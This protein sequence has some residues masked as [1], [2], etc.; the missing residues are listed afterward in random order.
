MVDIRTLLQPSQRWG[1]A[2][3]RVI[4]LQAVQAVL[5]AF[6]TTR[7]LIFLIIFLSSVALPMREGPFLYANPGN[8]LID[9][10]VRDDSWWY[11]NIVE[12][13]YSVGDVATHV[14]GNAVFF[15]LYPLL[16]SVVAGVTGSIYLAGILVS[17]AA[18]ILAL[19]YLYRLVRQQF[20][21]ETA[22]R[23]IFYMAAAPAA[24][25]F[26]AIYTESLY[27]ALVCATFFYAQKGDWLP[28]MLAGALVSATRNTGIILT[29]VIV[30]EGLHQQGVRIIPRPLWAGTPAATI[31]AWRG[32]FQQQIQL[33]PSC[34][35]SLTAAAWVPAGLLAFMA[36][37]T[38]QFNDPL[39]FIH[40]Q[41]T[42][43]RP[44]GGG[45]ATRLISHT[46]DLLNIG[47][48]FWAGQVHART[49]LELIYSLAVAPL[50]VAVVW[51]LRPAYGLYA[52]ASF[53]I[54]LSTGTVGS[55]LRYTLVLVPCYILLAHWGRR[56]WVDRL[57]V[58]VFLPLMA[59]LAIIFS[60]WY[61]AG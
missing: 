36:Y 24:V 13:G 18:F 17:N 51:K 12:H 28:A 46:I 56:G 38:M 37:L 59:Y 47:P 21:H 31:A 34:F 43:G 7:L 1:Q 60:H 2:L 20:D 26:S 52:A 10:L 40:T 53:L 41:A 5:V 50:I 23:A 22:A 32:H 61:F 49:L 19:S 4:D 30:F 3:L 57:V 45:S 29:G 27:V 55:M 48:H 11:V 25:F 33:L 39:A 6:L 9:G 8:L 14:Q 54:P 15:P 42:W 44:T 35:P 58:G 16:V